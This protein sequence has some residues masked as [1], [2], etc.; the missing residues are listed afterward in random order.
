MKIT[1]FKQLNSWQSAHQ[2]TLQIYQDTDTFPDSE[3]FGLTNQIR[4][5]AVSIESNIAEGFARKSQKEKS[6]FYYLALSSL[7]EVECQVEIAKDL[8]Y[9]GNNRYIIINSQIKSIRKLVSGLIR[10]VNKS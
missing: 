7:S 8:Q 3:K 1:S 6:H 9:V 5:A 10:S 4:R 2:L